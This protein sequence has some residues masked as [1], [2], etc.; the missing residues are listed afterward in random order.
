MPLEQ[1][2]YGYPTVVIVVF[3]KIIVVFG[4]RHH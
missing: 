3:I 4:A 2:E 1:K